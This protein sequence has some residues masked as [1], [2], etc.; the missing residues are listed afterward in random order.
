MKKVCTALLPL[1]FIGVTVVT[2]AYPYGSVNRDVVH[3]ALHAR[4]MAVTPCVPGW[5]LDADD[6]RRLSPEELQ[7]VRDIL[8]RA[9]V[10]TVHEK[11]YRDDAPGSGGNAGGQIF[12]LYASNAQCLGARVEGNT[13]QMDDLE[14]TPGDSAELYTVLRRHLVHLF[15]KLP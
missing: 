13:V 7:R 9:Q 8:H 14:L 5:L 4:T 10:R 11:Y 12:Y 6:I 15:P 1:L 3:E 2:C